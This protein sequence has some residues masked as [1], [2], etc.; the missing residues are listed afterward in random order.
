MIDEEIA[1]PANGGGSGR[2]VLTVDDLRGVTID[3]AAETAALLH[4][5]F[6]IIGHAAEGSEFITSD[7]PLVQIGSSEAMTFPIAADA[8][9]ML[10]R[11][12]SGKIHNYNKEMTQDIVHATNLATATESERLVLGRDKDYIRRVVEESGILAKES[13]PFTDIGPPPTE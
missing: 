11:S 6:W 8:A 4:D 2:Q 9:L 3:V 7:N 1:A 5:L 12:P 10:M 13:S